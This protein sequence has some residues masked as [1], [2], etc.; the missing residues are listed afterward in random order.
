VTL[1]RSER[2]AGARDPLAGASGRPYWLDRADVPAPPPRPTVADASIDDTVDL[3]VVGAGF[4]GLWAAIEA[5]RAGLSV[6]VLDAGSV[7]TGASGRCGGFIN[8]SITH[9]IAHG[10][11][12]WPEEMASIVALQTALWDDTIRLLDDWGGAG[13][14]QP[15]GKLTV[16]TRPHHAA[17]FPGTVEMLRQY[18][19][20][21]TLLDRDALGALVRSPTYLAGYRHTTANGLCDP[22][23]L[24]WLLADVAE[25]AGVRIREGC[26]VDELDD[27]RD[28]VVVRSAGQSV[29][30][31]RVLLATNAFTPLLRR[32][33]LRMIP[34]YDH[35]IVTEPLSPEQW[36]AIGWVG[37]RVDGAPGITDACN[38]FHYYRPTPDGG[39]LF[40]GWDAT[41]HFGGRV[42]SAYE[43]QPDTHR[44][45]VEHLRQTF[46]P[47]CDVAVT[48]AWGGPIDST[49]RFTPW[50]GTAA[51][52]RVGWAIGFTGLG[53][54]SSR[55]AALT[56]LDLLEGRSTDRT[57]LR[58]V[59]TAPIPFPPE[60][61]RTLAVS[62][63][64]RALIGEDQTGRRNLWLR[65]LDRF[66]V[67][68]DT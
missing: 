12:R 25:R 59:R 4:T 60:P 68:F 56:A 58:T 53:V 30:A 16:A 36:A 10:H 19:Q 51:G 28:Q 18:G 40:G 24:A 5:A 66:G 52:G 39:L 67:G 27:D 50:F 3:V 29:R 61:L 14:V 64:K 54:G 2:S 41:Y 1:A 65:L 45:L 8:A 46:P 23:R 13:V 6:V 62:T 15:S 26:R 44:L 55:F 57:A 31:R 37:D 48:H 42:D 38:Q 63:T 49:S 47:L 20:D 9:G 7:A 35:V 34:V 43:H 17:S 22:A 32:L 21:A 33:R 11:A